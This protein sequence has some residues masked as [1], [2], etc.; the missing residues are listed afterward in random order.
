MHV[1]CGTTR[2]PP[3]MA[4]AN[5]EKSLIVTV[6]H[7]LSFCVRTTARNNAGFG[8]P[9]HLADVAGYSNCCR[10]LSPGRIPS[11][12]STGYD[13]RDLFS[14]ASRYCP[15]PSDANNC[16]FH[17]PGAS[18]S[19]F[20]FRVSAFRQ[21]ST[22]GSTKTPKGHQDCLRSRWPF[23]IAAQLLLCCRAPY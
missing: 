13:Q 7:L 18:V 3:G 14:L 4:S 6:K 21:R 9:S 2:G 20:R 19:G 17:L 15:P 1:L 16:R 11:T 8:Q 5:A 10:V 23:P 12:I 22:P